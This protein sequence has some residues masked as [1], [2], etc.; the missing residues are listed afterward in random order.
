MFEYTSGREM[1]GA[2]GYE[3]K[4]RVDFKVHDNLIF[5]PWC[6]KNIAGS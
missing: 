1:P 6:H 2:S 5:K 4:D 3:R